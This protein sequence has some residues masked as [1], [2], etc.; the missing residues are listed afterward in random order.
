MN[1]SDWITFVSNRLPEL[2]LLTGQHILL[3][4]VSTVLAILAG[5]PL[6]ILASR[7]VRMRGAVLGSVG[8]LQTIPSLAM[9]AI[10]LALL[11]KIGVIPA[12]IALT[13]YA[14]LPIVRNT[15]TGLEGVSPEVMEAARGIGMTEHQQLW[16]VNVPLAMPFIIAGIRTAA[17]VG[18]G[19]AT[20]AAF[21]GAGGLGEFINRGLALSNTR[22][23]LL[24]AIPAAL[25]ALVV[26]FSIGGAEWGL[27]PLRK[28]EKG[29]FRTAL[30]R[31]ALVQPVFLLVVGVVAI[32]TPL[33]PGMDRT[34]ADGPWSGTIRIGSKRFSEQFIL[35][36]MM[37]QLIEDRTNLKVE[38]LFNLGG[39]MINH[40]ALVRGEIDLY[41]EYT[42]TALT[43]ILKHRA[44]SNPKEA[45]KIV[46]RAYRKR[47]NAEWLKPF[48]FNNSY[49][50]TVRKDEARRRGWD[51]I[52]DLAKVA[53][54]LRAGWTAEF[55]ERPDGYPGLQKAYG[56]RFGEVRDLDPAI[57][58]QA[59]A[60]G[61]VDV[62]C[63]YT[64][65]GRIPA[66]NLKPLKDDRHFFPPYYAA[67][68]VR[69]ETLRAHPE[70]RD[71][72]NELG[73]TLDDSTMQHLNYEVDE[74]GRTAREVARDFLLSRGLIN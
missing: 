58:Y 26:D 29:P 8:I 33:S 37:A 45:L 70:I 54:S 51:K 1:G 67:P 36:E 61:E 7:L 72:L 22:L 64:T 62:I 49:S 6:G 42:G 73:G 32:V 69:S 40:G 2:W 44:V 12:I 66:Y 57:M 4:G 39:T 48:G 68:V 23:I 34:A 41:P 30:K 47:F 35:G 20:L 60:R 11:G 50:I 46:R 74:K 14:L 27:R 28:A 71:V 3:T 19:I 21:I 56:F 52:S 59:V 63:A 13:L 16:M 55:S 53:P 10:L 31:L 24:G 65:D 9:L 38:R 17:V 25:L 43:A 5:I 18:V 15:L